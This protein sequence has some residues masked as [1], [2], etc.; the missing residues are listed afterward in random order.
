MRSTMKF[1]WRKRNI[2][3]SSVTLPDG[4]IIITGAS[5]LVS[6][7]LCYSFVPAGR[8]WWLRKCCRSKQPEQRWQ[9]GWGGSGWGKSDISL[10]VCGLLF[11]AWFSPP[12]SPS[13]EN[14]K[15]QENT[16]KKKFCEI[17]FSYYWHYW[18]TAVIYLELI[19]QTA[20]LQLCSILVGDAEIPAGKDLVAKALK[21]IR[22]LD[23]VAF[24][25]RGRP[26]RIPP[27]RFLICTTH[28]FANSA[29]FSQ[30]KWDWGTGRL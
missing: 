27:I 16:D 10:C 5:K 19:Q 7:P 17:I 6:L 22:I 3:W 11:S 14:T 21:A 4:R 20:P 28:G 9:T 15:Q 1:S 24:E 23:Q 8:R 30:S 12:P 13:K 26:W 2:T 29:T 18:R 25:S